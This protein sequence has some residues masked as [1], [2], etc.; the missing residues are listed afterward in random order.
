MEF[1]RVLFRSLLVIGII[2]LFGFAGMDKVANLSTFQDGLKNSPYIPIWATW[3]VAYAVITAFFAIVIL[4]LIGFWN[5]KIIAIGLWVATGL[6]L[7][8]TLY[9]AA[10]VTGIAYKPCTCI[11]LDE[12]LGLGWGAHLLLM[13]RSEE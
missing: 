9:V 7:I 3:P 8:F 6:L 5:P 11:G 10:I 12:S 13:V 1:R 4:L 2:V